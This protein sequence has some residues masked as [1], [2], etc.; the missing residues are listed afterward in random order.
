MAVEVDPCTLR[1]VPVHL[2]TLGICERAVED[3]PK[4]LEIVPDHL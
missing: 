4:T 2:K 3:K 1:Y